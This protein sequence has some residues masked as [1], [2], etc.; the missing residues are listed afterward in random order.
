MIDVCEA[1]AEQ[2]SFCITVVLRIQAVQHKT[3]QYSTVILVLSRSRAAVL[4]IICRLYEDYL[5]LSI[6][7]CRKSLYSSPYNKSCLNTAA[8]NEEQKIN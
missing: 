7:N 8:N 5:S 2:D 3:V 4:P 1:V 6:N